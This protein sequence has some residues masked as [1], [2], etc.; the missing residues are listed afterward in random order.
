MT[1]ED[2]HHDENTLSRVRDALRKASSP[3]DAINEMLN[4]G[5]VFREV[6]EPDNLRVAAQSQEFVND[7]A[8]DM[9]RDA[10]TYSSPVAQAMDEI[11]KSEAAPMPEAVNLFL[12]TDPEE[13]SMLAEWVND[14]LRDGGV[15]PNEETVQMVLN[16]INVNDLV[17]SRGVHFE[18]FSPVGF[19]HAHEAESDEKADAAVDPGWVAEEERRREYDMRM[20]VFLKLARENDDPESWYRWLQT[21]VKS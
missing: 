20:Q 21:G 2:L 9:Q 6:R 5:I 14:R 19:N 7:M 12:Y 3:V 1:N 11:T 16:G 4:A 17:L 18:R 10:E 15:F 8:K 13:L